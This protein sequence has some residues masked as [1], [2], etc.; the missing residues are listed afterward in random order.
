MEKGFTLIELLVVVLII[1]IL[2]AVA[3]PQY[4][5]AVEKSRATQ[6][7]LMVKALK[8]AGDRYYLANDEY[9]TSF[10]QLDV[11]IPNASAGTMCAAAPSGGIKECVEDGNYAYELWTEYGYAARRKSDPTP[12]NNYS[13]TYYHNDEP[14]VDLRNKMACLFFTASPHAAKLGQMCSSFG[15]VLSSASHAGTKYYI[16]P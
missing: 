2:A 13:I 10:S 15:G 16:I 11:S 9:P 8:D 1:A 4:T 14:N 12:N 6:A 5:A 7:M 3:L